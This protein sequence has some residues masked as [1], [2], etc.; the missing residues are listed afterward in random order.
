MTM[1]QLELLPIIMA[2]QSVIHP[3]VIKPSRSRI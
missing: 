3:S 2:G 1:L